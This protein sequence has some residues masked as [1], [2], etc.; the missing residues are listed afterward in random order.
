MKFVL[1]TFLLSTLFYFSSPKKDWN[2][3]DSDKGNPNDSLYVI[4]SFPIKMGNVSDEYINEK[5]QKI[6]SFY[7]KNINSPYYSGGFIVVKNGRVIYED[8]KGFA[9]LKT[10]KKL[11]LLLQFI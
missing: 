6:D 3:V 4:S 10:G 9:N 7:N 5:R 1:I 2:T 8:Y 11:T